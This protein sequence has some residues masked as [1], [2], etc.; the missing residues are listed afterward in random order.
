[1]SDSISG[2]VLRSLARLFIPQQEPDQDAHVQDFTNAR[3]QKARNLA[4]Y[5]S[6]A[7]E[8]P[9]VGGP[10]NAGEVRKPK[11]WTSLP[12]DLQPDRAI[13]N[14]APLSPYQHNLGSVYEAPFYGGV[15]MLVP[16]SAG[17]TSADQRR[18]PS[19]YTW[20]RGTDPFQQEV[21]GNLVVLGHPVYGPHFQDVYGAPGLIGFGKR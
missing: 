7:L 6:S 17:L 20:A 1:M 9:D 3:S 15:K 21:Y 11:R 19:G 13:R 14:M 8:A 12:S 16:P 4:A 18:S 5:I 2:A 10:M